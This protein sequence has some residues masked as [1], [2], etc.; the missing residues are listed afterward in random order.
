MKDHSTMTISEFVF[1]VV[2]KFVIGFIWYK[3]LLFRVLPHHDFYESL[4]TVVGINS[5]LPV[6]V[7][8]LEK[9]LDS[10]SMFCI[11][12]RYLYSDNL[13]TNFRNIYSHSV[14]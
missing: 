5:V 7:S 6:T 14:G 11:A 12:F 13:C 2:W 10:Y 1:S 9:Q 3:N 4:N 8:A